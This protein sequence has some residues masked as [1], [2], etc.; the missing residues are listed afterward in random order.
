MLY[1]KLKCWCSKQLELCT[2]TAG[3]KELVDKFEREQG[4][5]E[6]SE[7]EL[8]GASER[9]DVPLLVHQ[10]MVLICSSNTFQQVSES[11][12]TSSSTERNTFNRHSKCSVDTFRTNK[13]NHQ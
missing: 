9:V 13:Q 6:F 5:F 8:E 10:V 4:L 7:E 3:I 2:L 12:Q 11:S 1:I